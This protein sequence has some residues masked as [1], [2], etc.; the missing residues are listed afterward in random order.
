MDDSC[1]IFVSGN[2]GN[3]SYDENLIS[4]N[5]IYITENAEISTLDQAIAMNGAATVNVSGG[6]IKGREAVGLKRGT[7]N[8]TGGT[9]EAIGEFVDPSIANTNGTEATGAAISITSTYNKSGYI[10]ANVTGASIKSTNGY[11]FY[12]G[13][14]KNNKSKI[15]AFTNGVNLTYSNNTCTYADGKGEI[16]YSSTLTG[17]VVVNDVTV[18]PV[19]E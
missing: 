12:V 18:S 5:I 10:V 8:V 9:F 2:L 19:A 16:G 14:S 17:N 11:S 6:N 15:L 1:G 7:L 4:S 3:K 13:C